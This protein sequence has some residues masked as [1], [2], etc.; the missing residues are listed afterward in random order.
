MYTE[1]SH[2]F[3]SYYAAPRTL[4]PSSRVS[5]AICFLFSF[6]P[7]ILLPVPRVP[8]VPC[9]PFST[10]GAFLCFG[11][12]TRRPLTLFLSLVLHKFLLPRLDTRFPSHNRTDGCFSASTVRIVCSWLKQPASRASTCDAAEKYLSAS[13]SIT[14]RRRRIAPRCPRAPCSKR[15]PEHAALP[16]RCYVSR[17]ARTVIP[18]PTF[19]CDY[20]CNVTNHILL[21]K[22]FAFYLPRGRWKKA[23]F[24]ALHVQFSKLQGLFDY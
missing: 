23:F 9:R 16:S 10:N 21:I 24:P 20:C 8:H 4:I 17:S 19:I 22:L 3:P 6:S 18:S 15:Q 2:E 14:P 1:Q 12:Q 7:A 13:A 11:E 5:L